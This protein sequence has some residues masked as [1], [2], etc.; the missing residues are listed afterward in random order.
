MPRRRNNNNNEEEG[1]SVYFEM[2]PPDEII[3]NRKITYT[4]KPH[5]VKQ[6]LSKKYYELLTY[7]NQEMKCAICLEDIN[8]KCCFVLFTCGHFYHSACIDQLQKPMCATC[9]I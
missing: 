7:A 4:L 2:Y 5:P 3:T 1:D 6:N 9:G 8:C